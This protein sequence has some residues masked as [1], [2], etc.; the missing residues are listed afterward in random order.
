M[1][2]VVRGEPDKLSARPGDAGREPRERDFT[3]GARHLDHRARHHRDSRARRHAGHDRVVGLEFQNAV[4]Q[5]L[6]A[7]EPGLEAAAVRAAVRERDHGALADVLR[8]ADAAEALRRDEDQLLDERALRGEIAGVEGLG[9]ECRLHVLP[10]HMRDQRARGAGD[11][12]DL[13]VRIEPVVARQNWRQP[14]RR[15]AFQ[16]AEAQRAARLAVAHRRLGLGGKPQQLLGV[17]EEAPAFGGQHEPPA[18]AREELRAELLLE[19]SHPGGDV[20][21]HAVQPGGGAVDAALLDHRLEDAQ[22]GEVHVLYK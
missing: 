22:R 12:L 16:R 6:R 7:R 8:R 19:L 3:P 20:G 9:D 5:D 2:R 18:G 17:D 11:E 10:V 4:G 13:H 15:S 21:R 14:R 1:D